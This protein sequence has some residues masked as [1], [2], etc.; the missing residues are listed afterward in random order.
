MANAET[1]GRP[2]P[3]RRE[4][5]EPPF[6]GRFAEGELEPEA[7]IRRYRIVQNE[8][9]REIARE[10]EHYNLEAVLAVGF[11]VRSHRGTQFRQWAA[12]LRAL[13]RKTMTMRDWIVKLD[14]FRKQPRY[15]YLGEWKQRE[16]NRP[17]E[18]A[19]L[20]VTP[21]DQPRRT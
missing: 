10:V 8:G 13:Q 1:D 16:N 12:A 9:L 4:H 18:A 21:R 6:E 15:R 11:R 2:F 5:S 20:R 3:D 7:T 19:L 14:E 17:I